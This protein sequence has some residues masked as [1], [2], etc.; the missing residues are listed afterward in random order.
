MRVLLLNTYDL[1]GGAAKATWRVFHGLKMAGID[2]RLLVQNK[3]SSGGDVV[4]AGGLFHGPFN[5][6]RPYIDFAIPLLQTRKRILFSTNLLPDNLV[7]QIRRIDPDVVHLNWIAGGFIRI[8]SLARIGKPIVWTFHD[9]WG[10]TGGCHYPMD[11]TRYTGNCG[12]CPVLHSV[13]DADLSRKTFLRKEAVF[14]QIRHLT[15]LTPSH[16]LAGCVRNSTLMRGRPVHVVPNGL[17]THVFSPG[18]RTKAR[19]RFRLPSDKKIVLFGAVRAARNMTKGFTQLLEAMNL[20]DRND[21]ELVVF[22]STD[23]GIAGDYRFP[24]RFLGFI[25]DEEQVS[26]LYSAADVVAVPS[27]QEVFGQTASESLSCGIPVVAFGATGLLDIVD[28]HENGYLAH[29][30][31]STDLA[32]GIEWILEDQER[33]QLLSANARQKALEH[34]DIGKTIR[35][36]IGIYQDLI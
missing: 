16:W 17:D 1:K 9:L 33:W 14:Q 3:E 6:L 36:I 24:V 35:Q 22:G 28:H 29:P 11:C 30:F 18:N 15:I 4:A 2:A 21:T 34:F 27:S 25:P 20:V 12:S 23:P 19:E 8:E 32:R 7:D 10:A 13:N 5:A 26:M 31:E